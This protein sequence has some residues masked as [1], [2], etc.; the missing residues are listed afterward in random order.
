MRAGHRASV[1]A[2]EK[3][4]GLTLHADGYILEL[5][6]D[7]PFASGGYV[8]QHRLVM[9][10]CLRVDDPKSPFLIGL[11]RQLYLSPEFEVHH[12]NE[13]KRGNTIGNLE[14]MTKQEHTRHHSFLRQE[15]AVV[16]AL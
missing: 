12:K 11:G 8:L 7:H 2:F 1:T 13:D 5:S 15:V 3:A 10:R 9:E 6:P 14:C 16:T 4:H